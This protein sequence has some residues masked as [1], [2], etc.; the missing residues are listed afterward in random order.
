MKKSNSVRKNS[1]KRAPSR[2]TLEQIQVLKQKRESIDYPTKLYKQITQNK[3]KSGKDI[4][5]HG[6]ALARMLLHLH[7]TQSPF[8]LANTTFHYVSSS[9]GMVDTRLLFDLAYS[10]IPGFPYELRHLTQDLAK[11]LKQIFYVVF[12]SKKHVQDSALGPQNA[13]SLFLS[14][15]RY[16]SQKF[17]KQVLAKFESN[18]IIKSNS[19]TIPHLKVAVISNDSGNINDDTIIYM[20][21]HNMTKAAWGRF[22][23]TGDQLF[24]SN[25][26]M[27][28]VLPPRVGSAA[29]KQALVRK[30]GFKYPAERFE[31]MERPFTRL[32]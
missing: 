4:E 25:Y 20:G 1:K 21:S 7:P 18:G 30:L 32:G 2:L 26:E 13:N 24:V 31:K 27:G 29:K 11:Q 5:T 14:H 28:V 15:D 17:E 3:I 19:N 12:P 16:K 9:L 6:L 23:A 8:V 10:F 22:N